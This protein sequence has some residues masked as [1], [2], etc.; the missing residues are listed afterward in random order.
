LSASNTALENEHLRVTW[1]AD[2]SIRILDKDSGKDVFQ[3][4]DSGARA[5]VLNDPSDTWSHD[6]IDYTNEIGSF[7]GAEAR[8]LENGPLRARVRLRTHYGASTLESDLI[9]YA[10]GQTL[11]LRCKLDWHEHQNILKFSF[12]VVVESPHATFETAFGHIARETNGREM[13]G[14]RWIDVTGARDG[15]DYGLTI[16]NDA[17]YGYSVSGSDM[18]VSIVRGAVYAHHQP[19]KLRP[20]GEYHWQNQGIQTIRMLLVPH[21]G[22]WQGGRRDS[23]RNSR[24]PCP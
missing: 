22:R 1:S 7:G 17:K 3:G 20:D 21:T 8:V 19:S 24:P 5:L 10:G 18:R 4:K 2:G 6:V 13:P 16:I 15:L 23:P 14:Q 11:E 12:P 9:L